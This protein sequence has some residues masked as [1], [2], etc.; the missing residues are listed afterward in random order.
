MSSRYRFDIDSKY[1]FVPYRALRCL[2]NLY[3]AVV[4]VVVT[5]YG[6]KVSYIWISYVLSGFDQARS[7][8]VSP[9][10]IFH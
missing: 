6:Q 5:I 3:C 9:S 4:V 10:R 8:R 1:T 2:T 7:R